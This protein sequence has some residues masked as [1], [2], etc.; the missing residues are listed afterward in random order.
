LSDVLPWEYTG[1][2]LH[3]NQKP[4]IAIAPLIEAFSIKGQTVLDPFAGSGTTGVAAR[5]LGRQ[6]ILIEKEERYW[7]AARGRLVASLAFARPS[8]DNA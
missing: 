6:Y 5:A 3:P 7:C 1:N 2:K 4:V 8:L